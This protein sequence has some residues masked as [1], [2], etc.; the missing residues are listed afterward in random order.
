MNKKVLVVED[1]PDNLKL[2]CHLLNQAGYEV[3]GA[4]DGVE[5]MELLGQSRFDLVLSD[6]R[7]PG[8]DGFNPCVAHCLQRP[9]HSY[10]LDDGLLLRYAC[11]HCEAGRPIPEEAVFAQRVAIENSQGDRLTASRVVTVILLRC[12]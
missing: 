12:S 6:L 3:S 11:R 9:N 4:K 1:E 8:M 7:M 2:V 10:S 5:A